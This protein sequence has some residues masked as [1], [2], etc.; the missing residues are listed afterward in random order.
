MTSG[1]KAKAQRKLETSTPRDPAKRD[2]VR[3]AHEQQQAHP[4]GEYAGA[5]AQWQVN[6]KSAMLAEIARVRAQ[7][8][9]TTTEENSS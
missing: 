9:P 4:L 6:I 8:D 7:Q 1:R 2:P 5:F 3:E